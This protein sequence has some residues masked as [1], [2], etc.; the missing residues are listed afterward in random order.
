MVAITRKHVAIEDTFG[1]QTYLK[2]FD[3]DEVV[4]YGYNYKEMYFGRIA[5]IEDNG[6]YL[7][8][9]DGK[10]RFILLETVKKIK[11]VKK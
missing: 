1:Y 7:Q 4:V 11:K 5:G 3:G 10:K 2:V 6:F 9:N 8:P